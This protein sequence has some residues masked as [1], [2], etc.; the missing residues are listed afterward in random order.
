MA[1][2][3]ETVELL[4]QAVKI[5]HFGNDR[6]GLHNR[7]W[8]VLRFLSRANRFSRTPSAVAALTGTTRAT[9]S[10][11]VKILEAKSFL[12]RRPSKRDGRS[13]TLVVT[14][15]GEKLLALHDPLNG[16][17]DAITS[18]IPEEC[19]RLRDSLGKILNRIDTA[20]RQPAV[21]A[22]RDCVSRRNR[23]KAAVPRPSAD[24]HGASVP[25]SPRADRCRRGRPSLHD[26][27][28]RYRNWPRA[29]VTS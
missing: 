4:V 5:C 6:L 10:Q 13:T 28:A 16:L 17:L 3:R 15:Q 27:R 20:D 29:R 26:F 23:H 25:P 24:K 14:S 12:A 19:L 18:L 7:E 9:A 2:E 8:M 21:G 22:C 11:I 1:L